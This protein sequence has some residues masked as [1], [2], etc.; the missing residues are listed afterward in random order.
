MAVVGMGWNEDASLYIETR[1]GGGAVEVPSFASSTSTRSCARS[2]GSTLVAVKYAILDD[3]SEPDSANR[4][5]QAESPKSGI[6]CA[7]NS[8]SRGAFPIR[9]AIRFCSSQKAHGGQ[10][11]NA[12]FLTLV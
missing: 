6:A 11:G 5:E 10:T 9:I 3:D 2:S 1:G 12:E 7:R 4:I 8:T